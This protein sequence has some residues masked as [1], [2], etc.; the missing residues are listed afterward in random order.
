MWRVAYV[1]LIS[2]LLLLSQGSTAASDSDA[3]TIEETYNSWV[4]ATNAKDIKLWSSYLAP[5]ALFVP[6]GVPPLQTKEDIPAIR[7]TLLHRCQ[8]GADSERHQLRF[9]RADFR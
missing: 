6:P 5:S 3:L 8:Q 4:Q 7:E 2:G 1:A 9:N